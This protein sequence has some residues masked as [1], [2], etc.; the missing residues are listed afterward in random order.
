VNDSLDSLKHRNGRFL[1]YS[2][3]GTFRRGGRIADEM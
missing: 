3:V 2:E 1:A